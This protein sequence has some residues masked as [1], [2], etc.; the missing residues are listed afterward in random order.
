MDLFLGAAAGL[1]ETSRA[2]R[3][4]QLAVGDDGL[5]GL[6]AARRSTV[7]SPSV[8]ATVT[9]RASTVWSAFTT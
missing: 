2:G 5:A 9:G 3:Q 1:V 7:S 6:E 8:H 4:P